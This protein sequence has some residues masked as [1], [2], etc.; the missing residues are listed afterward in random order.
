MLALI[1]A[2]LAGPALAGEAAP[3]ADILLSPDGDHWRASYTLAQP[4]REL[5]FARED[6]QGHRVHDWMGTRVRHHRG[7]AAILPVPPRRSPRRH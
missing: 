4:A 1:V 7:R 5:R 6:R 3:L 2:S